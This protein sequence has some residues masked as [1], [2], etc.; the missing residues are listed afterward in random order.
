MNVL[1]IYREDSTIFVLKTDHGLQLPTLNLKNSKSPTEEIKNNYGFY[2]EVCDLTSKEI[3]VAR[4]TFGSI[5]VPSEWVDVAKVAKVLEKDEQE[6][7]LLI[8]SD[9]HYWQERLL[10]TIDE[11][12][13]KFKKAEIDICLSGGWAVDFL[14]G[15]ITR[16]HVDVDTYVWLK[17]K[18]N[19]RKLIAQMGYA[20]KDKGTKFQNEKMGGN[21][22]DVYF[23]DPK[24]NQPDV[25]GNV[26]TSEIITQSVEVK[27]NG[28]TARVINPRIFKSLLEKKV[29][30]N[31]VHQDEFSGP[32]GK[33]THD[34][35]LVKEYLQ[36]VS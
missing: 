6:I 3:V 25:M 36:T 16:P 9:I 34:L 14:A 23:I 8:E 5:I 18:E 30:Y 11:V 24:Q 4:R 28:V 26:L 20:I 13:E 1:L 15:R 19:V 21:S 7:R 10:N 33:T 31:Q 22:F 17:D 2:V 32:T 35:A 12:F 27:L 29:I